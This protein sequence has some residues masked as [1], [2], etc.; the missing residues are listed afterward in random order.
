VNYNGGS[1]KT[2]ILARS[3]LD[4]KHFEHYLSTLINEG[5]ITREDITPRHNYP[6]Q[7]QRIWPNHR[8]RYTKTI[9]RVTSK[10]YEWLL[11]Q[12]QQSK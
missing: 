2:K 3:G 10:G 1:L 7:A 6:H 4:F 12:Q 9:Y 11:Q 5:L 8:A